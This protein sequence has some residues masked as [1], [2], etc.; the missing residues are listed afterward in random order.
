MRKKRKKIVHSPEVIFYR[1][2]TNRALHN[3]RDNVRKI[4]QKMLEE[5]WQFSDSYSC[6]ADTYFIPDDCKT[7]TKP[8]RRDDT[9]EQKKN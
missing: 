4:Y 6:R 8:A 3:A 2:K 7:R 5:K 9:Q 1:D